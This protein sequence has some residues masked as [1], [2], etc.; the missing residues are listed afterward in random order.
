MVGSDLPSPETRESTVTDRTVLEVQGVSLAN[1]AGRVVLDDI[2]L[3][4]HAGEVLGIAGV[5]GNGQAELVEVV[6]G[7]RRPTAGRVLLD[8]NDI[9]E[10]GVREIREAGVGYIPEDW[11]RHGLL[12]EAPLW[13]NMILGHQTQAPN[14]RGPLID[15]R[16]AKADTDRV[17]HRGSPARRVRSGSAGSPGRPAA[18]SSR[19]P[20]PWSGRRRR[21]RRTPLPSGPWT[22]CAG[23]CPHRA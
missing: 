20:I 8:D 10:A 2:S 9:T 17:A 11:H 15:A 7:M 19:R 4:I 13:E 12:L 23:V 22:R 21:T 1:D 5:E 14:I 16:A 3:T 18:W 6:M